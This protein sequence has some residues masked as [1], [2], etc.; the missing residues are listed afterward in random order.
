M[1]SA[2]QIKQRL[3]LKAV[4]YGVQY[5]ILAAISI[6]L[7]WN[8]KYISED[9]LPV[10][11]ANDLWIAITMGKKNIK[12]AEEYFFLFLCNTKHLLF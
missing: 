5:L 6:L 1:D 10:F 11:C 4:P 9:I 7:L 3:E 12:A 2:K 8:L